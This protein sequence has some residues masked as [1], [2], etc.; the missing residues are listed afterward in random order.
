MRGFLIDI[1]GL[2]ASGKQTQTALLFNRLKSGYPIKK[3]EFPDY[4]D[5]SS[6]LVRMYLDG[7]FGGSPSD[8]NA[9]AASSFYAV[10]RYA[11]YK[12]HWEADYRAGKVILAD[13]YTSSNAIHQ[14]S[15]LVGAA[16]RDF[17]NWLYDYEYQ[18]LGIPKPDLVLYLQMPPPVILR[19]LSERYHGDE[20]RKDIHERDSRYLEDCYESALDA[21]AHYGWK[22]ICC[23][24]GERLRSVEEIHREITS[25]VMEQLKTHQFERRV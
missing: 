12:R 9:Y 8:V 23:M 3:I 24:D 10:D 20:A 14:A 18:K 15:K 17:L 16:R 2:D 25:C 1:E 11:S 22:L 4:D 7:Q 19:L 21:A 13:R 6:T 5:P